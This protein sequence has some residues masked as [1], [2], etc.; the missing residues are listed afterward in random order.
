MAPVA[1]TARFSNSLIFSG[2][3]GGA[4]GAGAAAGD[5][6]VGELGGLAGAVRHHP[7]SRPFERRVGDDHRACQ[8]GGDILFQS[9]H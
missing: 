8:P 9:G 6:L 2:S 5:D 1:L 3:T 4:G 7:G